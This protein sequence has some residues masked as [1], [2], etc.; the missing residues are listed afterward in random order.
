MIKFDASALFRALVSLHRTIFCLTRT[1]LLRIL[2]EKRGDE[3]SFAG[4]SAKL[5]R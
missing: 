5:V 3:K 4:E 1:E 2:R